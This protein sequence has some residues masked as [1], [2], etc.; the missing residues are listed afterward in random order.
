MSIQRKMP[1]RKG[2]KHNSFAVFA[3]EEE[4]EHETLLIG[5]SLV[6]TQLEDF[7]GRARRTRKR[8][9]MP[10]AR[11]ADITAASEEAT[12]SSDTNTLY[13]LHAGT[14]DVLQI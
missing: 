9:C 5:D 8:L 13:V 6:R 7:C 11:L 14:N 1:P 12:S 2:G 4:E 3:E 10:G